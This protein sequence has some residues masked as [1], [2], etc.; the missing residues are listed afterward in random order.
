M[1]NVR[2][3]ALSFLVAYVIRVVLAFILRERVNVTLA[4][5][6]ADREGM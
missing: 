1:P 2:C 5:Q 6:L 4:S 3:S